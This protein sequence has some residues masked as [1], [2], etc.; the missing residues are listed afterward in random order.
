MATI[1]RHTIGKA[2]VVTFASAAMSAL[3]SLSVVPVMGGTYD[4]IGLWLSI[5]CPIV[6]AFPASTWQFH[7]GEKLRRARDDLS[8]LHVEL[9]RMHSELR[10]AHSALE[11]K[12]RHDAMTGAL[13]REAFLTELHKASAG[14]R[15]GALLLADADN[16]KRI[17][18]SFGHQTG[19]EALVAIARAITETTGTMDFWG[20]IGGEEF[21]IFLDA[22][23]FDE[24]TAVAE[25]MRSR[26]ESTEIRREL[27]RVPVT[28]SIGGVAVDAGFSVRQSIADA[29]RRLYRAKR[30]GR[31]RVV[32]DEI[33]G[34]DV[35]AA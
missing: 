11:Q 32:L 20:R 27:G 12:A 31:N 19:D 35:A 4:G 15:R 29:D 16:F 26:V 21:A 13:T 28:I 5:I 23:G 2:L 8:R 6:I 9:D 34:D 10:R 14:G 7:Q 18:D 33:A 3:I 1:S 30:G 22:S 17:N 24:A 25:A